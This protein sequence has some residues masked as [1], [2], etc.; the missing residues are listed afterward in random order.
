MTRR[1]KSAVLASVSLTTGSRQTRWIATLI[2][3]EPGDLVQLELCVADETFPLARI[4]P[5]YIKGGDKRLQALSGPRLAKA[6][7]E[8]FRDGALEVDASSLLKIYDH[9]KTEGR[10]DALLRMGPANVLDRAV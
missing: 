4:W 6:V 1:P 10:T 8:L 9:F 2:G 7:L 5:P 3:Y